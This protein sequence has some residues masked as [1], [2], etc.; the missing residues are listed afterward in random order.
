MSE[1]TEALNYA[2]A[3]L[4][5]A[6]NNLRELRGDIRRGAPPK[7]IRSRARLVRFCL[8]G[9]RSNLRRFRILQAREAVHGGAR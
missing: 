3:C 9:A 2:K 1:T 8:R 5:E 4:D 6:R 7:E